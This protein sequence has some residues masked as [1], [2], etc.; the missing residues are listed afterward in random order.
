M[1][2]QLALENVTMQQIIDAIPREGNAWKCVL[3]DEIGTALRI[4][5]GMDEDDAAVIDA[6][7]FDHQFKAVGFD[8]REDSD[9]RIILDVVYVRFVRDPED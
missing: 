5:D 9:K 6:W 7:V 3:V 8:L 4:L 1:E 2:F